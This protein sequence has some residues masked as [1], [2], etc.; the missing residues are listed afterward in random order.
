MV[1][2][3]WY[4][5]AV[6]KECVW[7]YEIYAS[8]TAFSEIFPLWIFSDPK[9]YPFDEVSISSDITPFMKDCSSHIYSSSKINN[10]YAFPPP[11]EVIVINFKEV[12]LS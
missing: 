5:L 7:T 2:L 9:Y 12:L 6:Y 1:H 4:I 11:E 3:W 10:F 8:H